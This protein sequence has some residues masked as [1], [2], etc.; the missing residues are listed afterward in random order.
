MRS[1][2]WSSG[3]SALFLISCSHKPLQRPWYT[4]PD[5]PDLSIQYTARST[6]DH[7]LYSC[8]F[9]TGH[10]VGTHWT[11]IPPSVQQSHWYVLAQFSFESLA[12]FFLF[13]IRDTSPLPS[14]PSYLILTQDPCLTLSSF[15]PRYTQI[16]FFNELK[17]E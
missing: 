15:R 9:H 8:V 1:F 2:L 12:H 3:H 16:S 17:I 11:G 6:D 13:L 7:N 14:V 10:H 5:L 4:Q